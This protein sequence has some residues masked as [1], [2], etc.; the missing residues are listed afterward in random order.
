MEI[1]KKSD[2]K[3][4][5]GDILSAEE[6]DNLDIKKSYAKYTSMYNNAT[7]YIKILKMFAKSTVMVTNF[8]TECLNINAFIELLDR[9]FASTF[10]F[11]VPDGNME[12]IVNIYPIVNK[13]QS[14]A[15]QSFLNMYKNT[16]NSILVN[17]ILDTCSN[18]VVYKTYLGNPDNLNDRFLTKISGNDFLPIP[19]LNVNFKLMYY[20]LGSD[21]DAEQDKKF[22]I[23]ILHKLYDVSYSMYQEYGKS[24]VD[25]EKFV[26]SVSVI[27]E[28]IQKRV[29]GCNE[30]FKKIL[31]S[32]DM[33]R[34]NYDEYYKDFVCTKNTMIMAENFITD[35]AKSVDAT[36][37][38]ASQFKKIIR[39]MKKLM[40]KSTNINPKY[41]AMIDSLRSSVNES[42]ESVKRMEK[43]YGKSAVDD[44]EGSDFDGEDDADADG[45]GEDDGDDSFD[46]S[47]ITKMF[48]FD[49]NDG[50]Q[51]EGQEEGQGYES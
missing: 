18:L 21:K 37:K 2:V 24:D 22:I 36:P 8:A 30:A 51:E 11:S 20:Q 38:V 32:T 26:Q 35:V 19:D 41:K 34:D 16:K 48:N 23:L 15:A 5:I 12:L 6:I 13:E 27:I 43:E 17:T 46:F 49:D 4:A 3:K 28:K 14:A 31:E 39:E 33:L 42:F 44:D 29:P 1:S 10:P 45:K 47:K 9:E 25:T 50:G 40:A 7:R